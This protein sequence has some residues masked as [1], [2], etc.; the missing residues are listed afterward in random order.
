M[1]CANSKIEI[2]CKLTWSWWRRVD[3][4]SHIKNI[5]YPK[6]VQIICCSLPLT[7]T[8]LRRCEAG[9]NVFFPGLL[10]VET[11]LNSLISDLSGHNTSHC[12]YI[13]SLYKPSKWSHETQCVRN[14]S[15]K[16][17]FSIQI[18]PQEIQLFY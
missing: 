10:N 4:I 12:A 14:D 9:R 3:L 17:V 8:H 16:F 18:V 11:I 15:R 13:K 7:M 5:F 6:A 2:R 1:A